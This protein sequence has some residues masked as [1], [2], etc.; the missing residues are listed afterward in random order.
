MPRTQRRRTFTTALR[1]RATT[2]G[3]VIVAGAVCLALGREAARR[4]SVQQELDRL[5][6]QIT[7]AESS[8]TSLERLLAT[9]QSTTYEEGESRT[10][11]NLMKPG[12]SVLVVPDTNVAGESVNAGAEGADAQ[13][14]SKQ[15]NSTRWW[16][17][18]FHTTDQS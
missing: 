16:D 7:E 10:K 3:L 1:S 13:N 15:N 12:E 14:A 2:L 4:V 18:I 17:F 6:S 9:L 5:T 11:R 8:T